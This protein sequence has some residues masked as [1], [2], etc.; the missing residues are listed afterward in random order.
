MEEASRRA[1]RAHARVRKNEQLLHLP[2]QSS[3]K[4]FAYYT[5]NGILSSEPAEVFKQWMAK[6]DYYPEHGKDIP[7][8]TNQPANSPANAQ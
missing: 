1:H 4:S 3:V 6:H 2:A 8:Q 7:V 5:H